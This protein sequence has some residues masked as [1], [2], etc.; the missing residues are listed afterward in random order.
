MIEQFEFSKTTQYF[1]KLVFHDCELK[2]TRSEH[3]A[4]C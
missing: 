2:D 3:L 4:Y 1:S